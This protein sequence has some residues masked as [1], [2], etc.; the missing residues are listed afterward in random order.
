MHQIIG[1]GIMD[2]AGDYKVNDNY[3]YNSS[4]KEVDFPA[5]ADID[6]LMDE[7]KHKYYGE[8]QKLTVFERAIKLHMAIINIHPYIDGNGRLARLMMNYELIKNN[9]PP[10]LINESQKLSYYAIIEEINFNT[11][12]QEDPFNI[13][14]IGLFVET[15]ENLSVLTFKNMQKY[16]NR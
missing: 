6:K 9:Y 3:L 10:V 7:L 15:I 5:A 4:G 2:T 13:G 1:M 11:N 8:W 12:Y 14:D 16:Y